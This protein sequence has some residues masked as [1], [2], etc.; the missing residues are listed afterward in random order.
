[1]IEL[2]IHYIKGNF[3]AKAHF[4][5]LRFRPHS[6]SPLFIKIYKLRSLERTAFNSDIQGLT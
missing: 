1:M 2:T 3:K 4:S 5:C 6:I